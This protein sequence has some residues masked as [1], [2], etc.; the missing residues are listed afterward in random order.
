MV[1]F[2]F[3]C[4]T[5]QYYK[6]EIKLYKLNNH[7]NKVLKNDM[8]L[9]IIPLVTKS[10]SHNEKPADMELVGSKFRHHRQSFLGGKGMGR[11][12]LGKARCAPLQEK[13]TAL[14]AR[15]SRT[16]MTNL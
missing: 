12:E 1:A 5:V 11:A 16:V 4:Q 14:G 3:L 13:T 10:C 2:S 15:Q 6:C 7:F 9:Y 8:Q